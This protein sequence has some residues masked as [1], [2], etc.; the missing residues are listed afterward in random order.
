MEQDF[1]F[2][3]LLV[4]VK[5]TVIVILRIDLFSTFRVLTSS[6]E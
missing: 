2:P 5:G 3:L 6:L 1:A 4:L